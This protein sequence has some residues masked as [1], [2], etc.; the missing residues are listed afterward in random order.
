MTARML[1]QT[2]VYIYTYIYL[3]FYLDLHTYLFS[4]FIL[5]VQHLRRSLAADAV[6]RANGNC[7][8]PQTSSLAQGE[9]AQWPVL[10]KGAHGAPSSARNWF[11]YPEP[12]RPTETGRD[13][14]SRA[15]S[16]AVIPMDLLLHICLSS[17]PF[18]VHLDLFVYVFVGWNL[19]CCICLYLESV[20]GKAHVWEMDSIK[21]DCVKTSVLT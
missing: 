14:L 19:C 18:K 9:Q 8:T 5:L 13:R 12:R 11:C 20:P 3:Y 17:G 10:W 15:F 4:N 21:P 16:M 6:Q 1:L 7:C 2:Y